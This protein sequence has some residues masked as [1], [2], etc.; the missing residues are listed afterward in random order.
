MVASRDVHLLGSPDGRVRMGVARP[1]AVVWLGRGGVR[2]REPATLVV[3]YAGAGALGVAGALGS[4]HNPLSCTGWLGTRGAAACLLSLGL[5][6]LAGAATIAAT[7]A[8]VGRWRWARDLCVALRPSAQYSSD[9]ALLA[10]ALAGASGEELL[11]RGWLVPALGIVASS[12]VF[13]ALHQ[14]RG[15]ARWGW[16]AW[17]TVMGLVFAAVFTATGRLAGPLV[18]HAAI[19]HAN[20]KFLRDSRPVVR[21]PLGGILRR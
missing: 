1:P 4:G 2:W 15:P 18:A 14:V 16:M 13:G 12:V 5:G 11:F 20:L 3:A 21:R 10:V 8:M 17:A 19:N 6:V 7:H 9:R